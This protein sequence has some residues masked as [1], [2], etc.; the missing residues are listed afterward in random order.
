[1]TTALAPAPDQFSPP[2]APP[3][4][5]VG[6]RQKAAI[7]VRA[8]IAAG[9]ELNLSSLAGPLQ[10]ALVHE[11]AA[12]KF[13]DQMTIEA[14]I[15]EFLDQ[16]DASGL[17]FPEALSDALD[18]M[19][20]TISPG[21]ARAMRKSAGL[22]I[23]A[24]PWARIAEIDSAQLAPLLEEESTEVAAVVLSKLKVSKSAELL[25]LLPGE[26]ARR[27]AY[28]ISL[29]GAIAPHV[30]ERIGHTLAEQLDAEPD[31]AF[32]D[33]PVERVGAI[34]N[35]SPASTRDEVLDGLE[36][37]DEGFAREV[38]KAIFTY[39]HI[40]DRID[41]RDVPKIVREADPDQLLTALAGS[42]G[43]A[44]KSRSFILDNMSKRMAEQMG[45]DIEAMGAV[46]EADA[47]KAMTQVVV[48]IRELEAAGEIF[49]TS[50]TDS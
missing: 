33:G 15:T 35:Y 5:A 3:S 37:E 26:R 24:D 43:P 48:V 50:D 2:M 49:L 9:V 38:R 22:S 23:H 12:L 1:M 21:V 10:S 30:V 6:P 46:T 45:E 7:I 29:T 14:V 8:I 36:A 17:S 44:E 40:P 31:V 34:L 13:V 27:I 19:N 11:M 4:P 28:A 25:G 47:E 39:L 16:F 18:M 41:P 20:H 32:S 42:V